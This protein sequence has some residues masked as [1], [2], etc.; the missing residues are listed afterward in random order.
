[1]TQTHALND[2][3]TMNRCPLGAARFLAISAAYLAAR[4]A[5]LSSSTANGYVPGTN[6][7]VSM[8]DTEITGARL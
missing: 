4:P 3:E 5:A 1:M 8:A 6:R 7:C 2:N